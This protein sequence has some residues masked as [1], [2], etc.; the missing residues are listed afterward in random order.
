MIL[1]L[2]SKKNIVLKLIGTYALTTLRMDTGEK[3][4]YRSR[5]LN[6]RKRMP[7]PVTKTTAMKQTLSLCSR[8]LFDILNSLKPEQ[9]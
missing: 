7:L 3:S 2:V 5:Y 8:K 9:Q 1:F 6:L 4:N